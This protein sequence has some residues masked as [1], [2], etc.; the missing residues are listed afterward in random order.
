MSHENII[1]TTV[2]D[3]IE[4]VLSNNNNTSLRFY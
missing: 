2:Y 1:P 3:T 4:T